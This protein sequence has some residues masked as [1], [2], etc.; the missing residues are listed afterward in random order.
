MARVMLKRSEGNSYSQGD[1]SF[2]G[3][4]SKGSCLE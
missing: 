3:R 1:G 2:Q 4:D